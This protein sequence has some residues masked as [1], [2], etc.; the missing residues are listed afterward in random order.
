VRGARLTLNDLVIAERGCLR[1]DKTQLGEHSTNLKGPR[2]HGGSIT[3]GG[4]RL[5]PESVSLPNGRWAQTPA[6][7]LPQE[8]TVQSGRIVMVIDPGGAAEA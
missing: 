6:E 2:L 1:L 7:P 5:V 3:I 4:A 8:S